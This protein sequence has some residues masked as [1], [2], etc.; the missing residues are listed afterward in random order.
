MTAVLTRSPAIR[1]G[2]NTIDWSERLRDRRLPERDPRL[3][4]APT[5]D[6]VVSPA[7]GRSSAPSCPRAAPSAAAS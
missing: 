6:D 5:L 2:E 7:R 4:P 1:H 3:K